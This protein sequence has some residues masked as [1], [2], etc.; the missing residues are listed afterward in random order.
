M[1]TIKTIKNLAL[2]AALLTSVNQYDRKEAKPKLSFATKSVGQKQFH[3]LLQPKTGRSKTSRVTFGEFS[4][5]PE[6]SEYFGFILDSSEEFNV[7]IELILSVIQNESSWKPNAVSKAGAVGLMQVMPKTADWILKRK[8]TSAE[9]FEPHNNIRAGAAY[10]RFILDRVQKFQPNKRTALLFAGY[11]AGHGTIMNG[12]IPDY[13]E[14]HS[15]VSKCLVTLSK[16]ERQAQQREL[17]ARG[18][19]RGEKK[20]PIS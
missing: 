11:N 20:K 12:V 13:A 4:L 15:Y 6:A 1:K 7:P 3:H 18:E 9:L 10:L 2:S 19:N 8:F 14:T 16:L 17:Y 5:M